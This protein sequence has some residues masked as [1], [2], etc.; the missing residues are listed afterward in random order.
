L[1][2]LIAV[3]GWLIHYGTGRLL[4]YLWALQ[5]VLNGVW[6]WLFFGLHL[7]GP[8][9]ADISVLTACI[10]ALLVVAYQSMPRIV[11]LLLP[12]WVWVGYAATLN[13]AIYLR[14]TP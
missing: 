2:I 1:Y 7:T 6:S 5:L 3:A 13:A 10:A 8:A 14:N 12:Y 9:L 4:K 11:W